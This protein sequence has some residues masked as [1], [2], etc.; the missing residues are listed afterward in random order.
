MSAPADTLTPMPPMGFARV[1]RGLLRD[2]RSAAWVGLVLLAVVA[3]AFAG[4]IAHSTR[5]LPTS[6]TRLRL[7]QRATGSARTTSDGTS[8]PASS[9]GPARPCSSASSASW[10][11]PPSGRSSA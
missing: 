4:W 2:P 5:R 1:M 3:A 11:P 9:M 6:S 7:R 10:R 8:C